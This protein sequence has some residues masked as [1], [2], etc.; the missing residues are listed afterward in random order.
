MKV[1][2]VPQDDAHAENGKFKEIC[3]AVDDDGEH[4]KV[5]SVG[6]DPK[7]DALT[8]A[9]DEVIESTLKILQDVKDNKVSPIAFFKAKC[10]MDTKILAGYM[11]LP[12]FTVWLHHKPFFFK[13][14]KTPILEQYAKVF[15]IT[16]DKLI[17]PS[18][19]D[20]Y[21]NK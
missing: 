16:V 7:N 5:E 18:K 12:Y 3:Y 21:D 11:K 17:N 19:E 1:K 4:V 9:W 14:L 8:Q 15:N 20:V 13:R 6:W 2:D 10:I